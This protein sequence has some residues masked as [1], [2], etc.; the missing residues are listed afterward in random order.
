MPGMT[1]RLFDLARVVALLAVIEPSRAV[2]ADEISSYAAIEPSLALV[3]AGEGKN[4][5]FG[6]AFC[7]ESAGGYGFLLTNKHVVGADPH[8][9]VVLISNPT[10]ARNSAI[11]RTAGV[12][13]AV[14]LAINSAC[15][16]VTISNITPAVGTRIAIAGF[17]A[18]QIRTF[19]RGLGLSPSFHEG[20]I[21]S[22]VGDGALLQYDAQTDLGNSGS[23]LFDIESGEVDGL[24]T[25]V[26]TGATGALQNNIAI[27]SIALQSFLQNA[28]HDIAIG[29]NAMGRSSEGS[30]AVQASPSQTQGPEL[31]SETVA[32][33]PQLTFQNGVNRLIADAPSLFMADRGP[34]THDST[35]EI[36]TFTMTFNIAGYTDCDIMAIGRA[37]PSAGCT[38]YQGWDKAE[39]KQTYEADKA[40]LAAFAHDAG[41]AITE[42][43]ITTQIETRELTATYDA[44][45]GVT[46][47][48]V[49]ELDLEP[50]VS[51]WVDAPSQH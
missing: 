48:L 21:S 49:L 14:V 40:T 18:F 39:A 23:P 33:V 44:G 32:Q 1:P 6:T 15:V 3:V 43:L 8:P 12:L 28:R 50:V 45:G 34:K 46:V 30:V 9:R 37:P 47:Q 35:E 13:D 17:P 11:V 29:L 36:S 51:L 20:T 2:L 24:V 31:P 16:P 5:S 26:N 19:F 25:A 4:L 7:V 27:G 42:K 38:A 41:G 22:I 10:R